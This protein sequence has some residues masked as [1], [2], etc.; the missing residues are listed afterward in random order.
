MC[1]FLVVLLV[2]S[3]APTLVGRGAVHDCIAG[4]IDRRRAFVGGYIIVGIDSA[5]TY[6]YLGTAT[7]QAT[8]LYEYWFGDVEL[9]SSRCSQLELRTPDARDIGVDCLGRELAPV[10]TSRD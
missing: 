6:A 10:C 5:Q 3:V 9:S 4:A 8:L 2:A 7:G 1:A